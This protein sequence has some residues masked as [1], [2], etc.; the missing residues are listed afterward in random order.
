[1]DTT[2]AQLSSALS[3]AVLRVL[4]ALVRVLVRHGMALPAFV[5]LAKRAYVDVALHDFT[6]PGRKPSVSRAALLTGLTRKE[7]QRLVERD[8]GIEGD[9]DALPENRAARV[10]AG[11][12][13]DSDFQ[14]A[15]GEARPL[16]FDGSEPTFSTLVR[17]YSG[18]MPPRAVLDELVRV[19]AVER[20]A[21]GLLHLQSR[22][23]IPR[24]SDA[25]K[26]AILA[27]DVPF[28]IGTIDHNLQGLEPSRFQRKV[29]Y[30]NLPVEAMDEFRW[31]TARHAQELIELL[32]GWL[33]RHDR[34]A[35]PAVTGTGRMR[36]G[37]SVFS[38]EEEIQPPAKAD[39]A[40]RAS[41]SKR[42]LSDQE[43]KQ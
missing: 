34:D 36:A 23:Y 3:Q 32:D 26:L 25:A 15:R 41:R 13:R 6:I 40:A 8:D 18:D 2:T 38:F 9:G 43:N 19:G 4:R 21:D 12:V 16:M 30:D 11:W 31:L 42:T 27:A 39:S 1:M 35:N 29:M 28:L 5:E 10:V 37:L 33:A 24:A 17:R 7:V 22:V 14:D 20:H